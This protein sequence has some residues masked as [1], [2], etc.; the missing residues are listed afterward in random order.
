MTLNTPE[1]VVSKTEDLL[2][3]VIDSVRDVRK[4]LEALK[5]RLR[6]REDIEAPQAKA[7]M[8]QTVSLLRTCQ[9]VENRLVECSSKQSGIAQGGYALDLAKA[10]AEIGCKLDR[11]RCTHP[12]GPILE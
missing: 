12:S 5:L 1:L 2:A 9:E 11:L 7:Q 3:S 6:D 4:E 8:T 10:R